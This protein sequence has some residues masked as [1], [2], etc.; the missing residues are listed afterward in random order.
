MFGSLQH[1]CYTDRART[2]P[3]KKMFGPNIFL[4]HCVTP[5]GS[6]T[7]LVKKCLAQTFF[8]KFRFEPFEHFS[9]PQHFFTSLLPRKSDVKKCWGCTKMFEGFK[10]EL[11]KKCWWQTIFHKFHFDP[12]CEKMF[13]PVGP[14]PGLVKKCLTQTCF[15]TDA[16]VCVF[17][18]VSAPSAPIFVFSGVSAPSAPIFV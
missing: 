7:R 15:Y 18:G 16:A 1:F 10:T 12:T 2:G 17:S 9:H 14:S 4:Q 6:N 8:H 3:C 13:T 11:V 5:S